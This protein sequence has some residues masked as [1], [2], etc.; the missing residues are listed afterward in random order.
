MN[1]DFSNGKNRENLEE[2][3]LYDR[4]FAQMEKC[5]NLADELAK[6]KKKLEEMYEQM[7]EGSE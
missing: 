5:Y 7:E 1:D 2:K 4:I 3:D 6:E